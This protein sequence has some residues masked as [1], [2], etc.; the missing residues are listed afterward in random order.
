MVLPA[1]REASR[2]GLSPV[3]WRHRARIRPESSLCCLRLLFEC[4]KA[5]VGGVLPKPTTRSRRARPP[6]SGP[7]RLAAPGGQSSVRTGRCRA[8]EATNCRALVPNAWPP[9]GASIPLR[10]SV[11]GRWSR[12]TSMVSPSAM[13]M[14]LPENCA[15]AAPAPTEQRITRSRKIPRAIRAPPS[16]R[17]AAITGNA[18]EGCPLPAR[19]TALPWPAPHPLYQPPPRASRGA[20]RDQEYH[21]LHRVIRDVWRGRV[22]RS[23]RLPC[24]RSVGA[25]HLPVLRRLANPPG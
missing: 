21:R 2:F 23:P 7:V 3:P 15:G 1:P 18:G 10:R 14:T 5:L 12:S 19:V 9:S 25:V 16:K 4:A 6:D 20:S 17:S 24:L 13:P 11:K 8:R 22:S